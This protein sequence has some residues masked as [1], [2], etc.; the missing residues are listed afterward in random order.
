MNE[1]S[2]MTSL[3]IIDDFQGSMIGEYSVNDKEI[4]IQ[5][6]KEKATRYLKYN[7]TDYNLH[8]HFGLKNDSS[9]KLTARICI[10]T[11]DMEG[12]NTTN[13]T[14]WKS[15]SHSKCYEKFVLIDGKTDLRGKYV[16]SLELNSDEV[17]YL[18]NFMP[19]KFSEIEKMFD[20]LASEIGAHMNI[21]GHTVKKRPIISYEI[22][23]IEKKPMILVT[24]GYHPPEG[25]TYATESILGLFIDHDWRKSILEKN[26]FAIIPILNP[27]G[28]AN[29]MQGSNINEINFHWKFFGNSIEE[30]P[31]SY[32]IW[33]Y[34]KH[35]K[36]I[37]YMD[38]HA[39]TFQNKMASSYLK[40]L[41]FYQGK[42]VRRMIKEMYNAI[43]GRCDGQYIMNSATYTPSTLQYELTRQFNTITF[44][45]F[46]VDMKDGKDGVQKLAIGCFQD[47]LQI[48]QKYNIESPT[49][50]L[51]EPHG[52]VRSSLYEMIVQ[53]FLFQCNWRIRPFIRNIIQRFRLSNVL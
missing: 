53:I 41:A 13:I 49:D 32:L 3:K 11:N 50:I 39:Y 45:K 6:K 17:I 40:P 4:L 24:S 20:T 44:A 26:S 19:R 2:N 18:A 30:C 22:G 38:F 43:I 37:I 27:D 29:A 48:L 34:C 52:N 10:G 12:L 42:L 8:F 46:H 51:K 25:D 9:R 7:S 14:L 5:L 31:E 28:F 47:I 1:S 36:P 15:E 23:D 21:I 33:E 16:F 35:L